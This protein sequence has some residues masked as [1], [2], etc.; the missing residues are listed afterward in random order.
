[1]RG[2]GGV[3]DEHGARGRPGQGPPVRWPRLE[4]DTRLH[5]RGLRAGRWRTRSGSPPW[6]WCSRWPA[7]YG[8]DQLDA[9]VGHPGDRGTA[10]RRVRP[11]LHQRGQDAQQYLPAAD[12]MRGASHQAPSAGPPRLPG[13]R[14]PRAGFDAWLLLASSSEVSIGNTSRDTSTC[15]CCRLTHRAGAPARGSY[16]A[17]PPQRRHVRPAEGTAYPALHQLEDA[18]LLSSSWARADRRRRR[19]YALTTP[20]AATLATRSGA[21]FGL[22]PAG[23]GRAADGVRHECSRRRPGGAVLDH[24]GDERGV[25]PRFRRRHPGA[26]RCSAA[27]CHHWLASGP[28]RTAARRPRCWRTAATRSRCGWPR[29]SSAWP[30]WPAPPGP[31]GPRPVPGRLLHAH[32]GHDAVQCGRAGPGRDTRSMTPGPGPALGLGTTGPGQACSPRRDRGPGP[33]LPLAGTSP[34]HPAAAPWLSFFTARD[35]PSPAGS[36]ALRDPPP[37]FASSP[38]RSRPEEPSGRGV[39]RPGA[40]ARGLKLAG[41]WARGLS[42][43]CPRAPIWAVS[44][45]YRRPLAGRHGGPDRGQLLR[46]Q[47]QAGTAGQ[48]LGQAVPSLVP[49]RRDDVVAAGPVPGDGQLGGAHPRC[50]AI[51]SSASSGVEV[52]LQLPPWNRAEAAPR[53]ALGEPGRSTVRRAAGQDAV[54]GHADP[55]FPDRGQDLRLDTPAHQRV[56]DLQRTDGMDGIGPADGVRPHLREAEVPHVPGPDHLR[57]RADRVLDRDARVEPAA[58]TGPRS[59]CRAGSASRPGS[60]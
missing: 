15:S 26:I 59:R 23:P 46:G 51:F 25:R 13:A 45:G 36:P 24:V 40:P 19:V 27:D 56:L 9:S 4:S 17:A 52:A 41:R 53:V 35:E 30:R 2:R 16:R 34:R 33:G 18:G 29:A 60:S 8:L 50:S 49:I 1:M 5:V 54:R 38:G 39:C 37:R 22:R 43:R 58:G 6:T 21:E 28:T 12:P 42:G 20:G 3:R 57:D 32:G 44:Y 14:R 55:E 48:H 11:Q 10:G 7:D 47:P 31:A